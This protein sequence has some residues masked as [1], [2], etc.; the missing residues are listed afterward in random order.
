MPLMSH[1]PVH[2]LMLVTHS[3]SLLLITHPCSTASLHLTCRLEIPARRVASLAYAAG[4]EGAG[5]QPVPLRLIITTP[6][7][8]CQP[9]TS[10]QS[11]P[12]PARL[13]T[14]A[15]LLAAPDHLASELVSLYSRMEQEGRESGMSTQIVWNNHWQPCME[16]VAVC[17]SACSP[18]GRV[19]ALCQHTKVV[20]MTV[21]PCLT[22]FFSTP[23]TRGWQQQMQQIAE[24]MQLG[25]QPQPSASQATRAATG[26]RST[27]LARRRGAAGDGAGSSSQGEGGTAAPPRAPSSADPTPTSAAGAVTTGSMPSPTM[28]ATY[29]AALRRHS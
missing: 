17:L 14:D 21:V 5:P 2:C 1:I 11:T 26:G 10:T 23:A 13:F 15:T 8:L 19:E 4:M 6:S 7:C 25:H 28:A 16:D 22:A 29:V 18:Y 27:Q 12:I 20:L 9:H 24:V 3:C